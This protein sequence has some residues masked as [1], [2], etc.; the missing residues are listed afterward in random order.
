MESEL[1]EL[2]VAG[3]VVK[4]VQDATLVDQETGSYI[5]EEA[6]EHLVKHVLEQCGGHATGMRFLDLGCG[7][8]SVGNALAL[9][10]GD[11]TLTDVAELLPNIQANIEAN[12]EAIAAAGGS[13]V[14]IALDWCGA[15]D[16]NGQRARAQLG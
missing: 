5:W 4:V 14:G 16:A 6:S 2:P 13:S 3:V 12:R 11:V 10:G 7:C 15:G 8:G 9:L 1:T